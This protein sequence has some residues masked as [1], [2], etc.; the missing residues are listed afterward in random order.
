MVPFIVGTPVLAGGAGVGSIT[1][2]SLPA[3][4]QDGDYLVAAVRQQAGSTAGDPDFASAGFTRLGPAFVAPNT[5]RSFGFFGK[6]V[7]D[8][9]TEPTS[10][11]FTTGAATRAAGALFLVRGVD[12]ADP[13]HSFTASYSGTASGTGR[14][15]EAFSG[16][17]V[18]ALSLLIGAGEFTAGISHTPTTPP[19]GWTVVAN[20][21]SS[22]DGSTAGSRTGLWAG[23][24]ATAAGATP[25]ATILWSA[26]PSAPGA[27]AIALRGKVDPPISEGYPVDIMYNGAVV[28][29]RAFVSLGGELVTPAQVFPFYGYAGF[30]IADLTAAE[31][32]YVAHRCG[33]MNWP[34]F[35]QRGIE[36]SIAKGYK[37]LE[38]SVWRASSGEFVLSHDW[39]TTRMTG[40]NYS[41]STTPWSTLSG[42][43]ST[44]KFTDNPGQSRTPLLRLTEA[45][46]LAPDRVV[47]IEH[48]ATGSNLSPSAPEL[49]SEAQLL[50]YLET[51]PGAHDRFVWKVFKDGW[52][53][54]ERAR[55][56][57]FQTWIIYY[58]DDVTTEPTRLELATLAGIEFNDTQAQF[59]AGKA[60]GR[61]V[62]AHIIASESQRNTAL[63]KGANGFM[64]SNVSLMGP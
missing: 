5:S 47:F 22:L 54:A 16:A 45:L 3:G 38:F 14:A 11:T 64:N 12:L 55:A 15:T 60:G 50:D 26:V 56:R 33:G 25:A 6:P 59:D 18:E 24:R 4:G 44:A 52:A 41:I 29:A 40:V 10:H 61:K 43:T 23:S 37:A 46:A 13:V 31:P 21:Q 39:N 58:D 57:G 34:E 62:V 30:T 17:D 35:S 19:A 28:E 7:A 51:I 32:F 8:W 27:H 49:A 20:V 53:S 63:G 48:K 1:F 9:E 36:N 2:S 42:L